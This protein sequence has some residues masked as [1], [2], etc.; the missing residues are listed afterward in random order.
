MNARSPFLMTMLFISGIAL[1]LQA[2]EEVA[3]SFTLDGRL[4]SNSSATSPLE[5]IV[6][7][8]VQILDDSQ[9]CILY[10]EI[11][12]VDTTTSSGYYTIQVGQKAGPPSGKRSSGDSNNSMVQVFSNTVTSISGKQVGDGV[13][14]CSYTPTSNH[15]RYMK[16][17]M[18]PSDGIPRVA[19]SSMLLD[20]VPMA[21]VAE[22]AESLRGLGPS[23]FIQV[24][25]STSALT[26]ANLESIM[27]TSGVS[28]LSS[29][30][31]VPSS[32][33]IQSSSTPSSGQVLK[34]NGAAWTAQADST[35]WTSVDATT[36]VKGIMQ[37]GSGLSVSSGVVSADST[38]S[39][40]ASKLL[41]L[42]S[43]GQ[44]HLKGLDLQTGTGKV[45]IKTSGAFTDYSLTLP[46]AAPSA[47]QVLQSDAS[48]VL[49][50][51]TP[52]TSST[53]WL[54]GG[55]SFAADSTIGSND[56]YS[57]GIETNNTTRMTVLSTGEVGVGTTSPDVRLKIR[58]D[59][60]AVED[61][62]TLENE[63]SAN[64]N[65]G[66]A[67]EFEG[68]NGSGTTGV[69][70]GRVA[71]FWDANNNNANI[72]IYTRNGGAVHMGFFVRYDGRIRVGSAPSSYSQAAAG[73][74]SE[75][76]AAGSTVSTNLDLIHSDN[77]SAGS[78]GIGTSISFKAESTA[79][80]VYAESSRIESVLDDAT[81]AS[82]DGSLRFLTL[83]PNAAA[84]TNTPTE[85]V[86][87]DSSG[88]LGIGTTSPQAHLDVN[89]YMR[90]A[91]NS[92]Q[93]VACA[94][95]NDGAIALTSSYKMCVCKGA[96]TT[97]VSASD[98]SS[99]CSW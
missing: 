22:R 18:T 52:L 49:S 46:T 60:A 43:S 61:V 17:T 10:E 72:G 62:L 20:S 28:R 73:A 14:A 77:D 83:G 33:Y 87:V 92:S 71:S 23:Q 24:N 30:I 68:Q 42:D 27:T 89:G 94:A 82:K 74:F 41:L 78:S 5:D 91:K 57:F 67:L 31:S 98:G 11:Q 39:G 6:A 15:K 56:A 53:A 7:L 59:I 9:A 64:W 44:A 34:W 80:N 4:Y 97:W 63:Q 69:T 79:V 96:T 38:T 50:W 54:N 45:N 35:G 47:G 85:K 84:G 55:N 75:T 66:S 48:G 76:T 65:V 1:S 90:L 40:A 70:M 3:Q 12:S 16:V 8:K 95:G 26:Q 51:L 58:K 93:P 37:V 32:N 13:T 88:R 81:D 36:S 25:N 2:A 19:T 29:L 99:P 86:R 21:W